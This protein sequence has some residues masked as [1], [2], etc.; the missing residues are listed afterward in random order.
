M[1]C[2]IKEGLRNDALGFAFCVAYIFQP[3]RKSLLFELYIS[4]TGSL[5]MQCIWFL[6]LSPALSPKLKY[7]YATSPASTIKYQCI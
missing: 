2:G 4:S 5:L 6:F 3:E 7:C 1:I